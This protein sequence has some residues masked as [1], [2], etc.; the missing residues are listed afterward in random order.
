I[1]F[2]AGRV[3]FNQAFLNVLR[4]FY[5]HYRVQPYMWVRPGHLPDRRFLP[6]LF[7]HCFPSL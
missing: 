1:I 7:R 5:G 4:H 3:C 2:P 6:A